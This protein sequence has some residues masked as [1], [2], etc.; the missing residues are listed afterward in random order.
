MLKYM[1]GVAAAALLLATAS[2][3]LAVNVAADKA[4]IEAG[5]DKGYARLDALYKDIHQNP[6]LG[7]QETATAAK[8]AKEMRA[9]GFE[10][11]EGVGKT[12]IVAIYRNGKGPTVL[13][14]TEMDGLPMEEKTGLPYASRAVADWNG[15][16]RQWPTAAAT[17]STWPPGS[18]PPRP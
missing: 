15:S 7:F 10:V 5:L 11:T 13:V 4:A 8:L 1:T 14:R 6:E 2:P 17:T 3:V 12:G 9:L 18:E 16:P